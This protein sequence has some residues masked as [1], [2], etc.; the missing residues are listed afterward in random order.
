MIE[1]D[2]HEGKFLSICRHF[3]AMLNKPVVPPP[4]PDATVK[5]SSSE[6]STATAATQVVTES[7]QEELAERRHFLKSAAVYLV[8]S[9]FD[10]EQS[11][12]LHRMLQEKAIEDNPTYK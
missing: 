7:S 4:T 3:R 11:D 1:L 8:L 6:T 2:Q 5:A 10:N 12:L 9:P